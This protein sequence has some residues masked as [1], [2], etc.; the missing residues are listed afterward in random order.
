MVDNKE[1]CRKYY[2]KNREKILKNN[3][4]KVICEGC[5]DTV[6][7]SSLTHHLKTKLHKKRCEQKMQSAVKDVDRLIELYKQHEGDREKI[8]NDFK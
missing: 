7:R 6:N 4:Q 8:I 1:Y 5:G 3:K 2:I